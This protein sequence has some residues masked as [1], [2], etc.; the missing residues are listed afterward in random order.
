MS[1][2]GTSIDVVKIGG[3]V[4]KGLSGYRRAATFI[5]E[6]LAEPIASKLVVV[7]S[8]ESGQTDAL[9]EKARALEAEPD[10][11]MLDLLW[12][13][14][15]LQSVA[16]LVLAL[17]AIGVRATGANVHQ[18]GLD[19]ALDGP[20]LTPPDRTTLRPLRLL[21]LLATHDVVVAPGFLAR[22]AGD[23]VVSLG[24]GGSD[25][26]A[27]LL[28][29]GLGARRCELVKDVDGYHSSDPNLDARARH[30]PAVDLDRALMMAQDGCG[31]IQLEALHA[32]KRHSVTLTVR[33]VSGERK[34]TI[35][36]LRDG[37]HR[38]QAG[39]IAGSE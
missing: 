10:R 3:S 28:A 15:E 24:R 2:P 9:L 23:A 25:L 19:D 33:S 29:G 34:T 32:A 35:C 30:L 5:A 22:G 27:V 21:S 18:T 36:G 12:S 31:L 38:P 16:L 26:S 39:A 17:H 4:L 13:T 14:G 1:A 20:G 7:V 37:G 6:R 11:A 8:A